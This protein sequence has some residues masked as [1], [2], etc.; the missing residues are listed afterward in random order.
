MSPEE[1]VVWS[2][3]LSL[4]CPADKIT[5]RHIDTNFTLTQTGQCMVNID[6]RMAVF[7]LFEP[8]LIFTIPK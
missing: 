2:D 6:Y 1:G 4:V 7:K 8:Q 5:D 3:E